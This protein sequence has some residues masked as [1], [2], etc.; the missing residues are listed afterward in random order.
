MRNFLS[1]CIYLYVYKLCI[2]YIFAI[3]YFLQMLLA[4]RRSMLDTPLQYATHTDESTYRKDRQEYLWA[5]EGSVA[6]PWASA[7][8]EDKKRKIIKMCWE[9]FV[10]EKRRHV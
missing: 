7:L 1:I 9:D 4:I 5:H 10:V 8:E 3:S 2:Y 6:P